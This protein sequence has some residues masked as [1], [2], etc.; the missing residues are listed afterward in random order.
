LI[1]ILAASPNNPFA[2]LDIVD[3]MSH[4]ETGSKKDAPY[5][6]K[7][8]LPH[9]ATMESIRDESNKTCIGVVDLVLFDG[10]SNIQKAILYLS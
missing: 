10:A 5:L 2:L 1:N 7:M 3:C 9:I 4:L 6:A 8:I